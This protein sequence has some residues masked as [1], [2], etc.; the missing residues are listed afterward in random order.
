MI[1]F[2]GE[3]A[4]HLKPGDQLFFKS[5]QPHSWENPANQPARFLL[6]FVNPKPNASIPQENKTDIINEYILQAAAAV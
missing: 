5:S 6:I 1:F 2:V 3:K 4:Y